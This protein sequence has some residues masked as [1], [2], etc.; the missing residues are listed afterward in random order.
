MCI[1]P[2]MLAPHGSDLG[3]M[4][5]PVCQR[6]CLHHR[7]MHACMHA[8]STPSTALTLSS[9]PSL[10]QVARDMGYPVMIKASAGGGGKGMRVV[11]DEVGRRSVVVALHTGDLAYQAAHLHARGI[12]S[13]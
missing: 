10:P 8:Y 11:R 4:P 13:T 9:A 6:D 3:I 5:S 2:C 12:S 1:R 7:S